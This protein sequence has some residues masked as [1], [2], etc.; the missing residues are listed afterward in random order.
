MSVALQMYT[1]IV[2]GC[3]KWNYHLDQMIGTPYFTQMFIRKHVTHAKSQL[4]GIEKISKDV[5]TPAA[6]ETY[7]RKIERPL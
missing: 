6:A 5:M 3:F 2:R 7:F 1:T 4:Q